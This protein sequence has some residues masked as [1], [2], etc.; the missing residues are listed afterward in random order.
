MNSDISCG[1]CQDLIPLVNDGV[2]SPESCACVQQHITRCPDCAA[3][4][5]E[6]PEPMSELA[7]RRVVH[8]IRRGLILSG[9]CMLILGTL[10]GVLLSNSAGMFYNFIIMPL[11]GAIGYFSLRKRWFWVPAGVLALSLIQSITAALL[12]G[13]PNVLSLSVLLPLP[14]IYAALVLLGIAIAAL[15][16]FAFT[17]ERRSKP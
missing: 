16:K 8:S 13:N 4:Y 2:A 9:V 11:V 12:E 15:L 3:L 6:P 17:P 5:R 10:A 7:Q 14:I 1:V